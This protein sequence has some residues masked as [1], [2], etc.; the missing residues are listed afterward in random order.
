MCIS[1]KLTISHT[2]MILTVSMPLV[3]TLRTVVK[4]LLNTGKLEYVQTPEFLILLFH[5][6]FKHTH[7]G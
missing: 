3:V 4:Y 5:F 1:S 7:I 2:C 6:L